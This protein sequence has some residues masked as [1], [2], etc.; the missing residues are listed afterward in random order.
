[1]LIEL[2]EAKADQRP[3][4]AAVPGFAARQIGLW[5][6]HKLWHHFSGQD[7]AHDAGASSPVSIQPCAELDSW[8]HPGI[9]EANMSVQCGH[10]VPLTRQSPGMQGWENPSSAV[11]SLPFLRKYGHGSNGVS[12]PVNQLD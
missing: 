1:M 11:V 4:C 10:R 12:V 6:R 9:P 2:D 3:F 8:W 5:G 7:P